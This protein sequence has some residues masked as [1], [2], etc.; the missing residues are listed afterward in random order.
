MDISNLRSTLTIST[1][2]YGDDG[3]YMCYADN[4][5]NDVVHSAETEGTLLICKKSISFVVGHVSKT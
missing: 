2:E 1:T 5:I 3:T 4:K